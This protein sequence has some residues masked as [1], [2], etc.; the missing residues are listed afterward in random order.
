M[1]IAYGQPTTTTASHYVMYI[2]TYIYYIILIESSQ[3]IL[4]LK[5]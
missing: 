5:I 2:Y 1:Y 3:S 4:L